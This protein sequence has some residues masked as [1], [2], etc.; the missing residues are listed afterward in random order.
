MFNE[1]TDKV[2]EN[3]EFQTNEE[4]KRK[5]IF[6]LLSGPGEEEK[7]FEARK[8]K[9]SIQIMHEVRAIQTHHIGLNDD[10]KRCQCR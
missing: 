4:E 7:H 5:Q 6:R 9:S 1:K 3:L 8:T 2:T 10:E